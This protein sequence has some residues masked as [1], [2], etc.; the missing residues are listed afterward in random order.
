[1]A[2]FL[3]G[4]LGSF[5]GLVGTV[6]GG[7]WRGIDYIRSRPTVSKSGSSV[8][9]DVHRARFSLAIRFASTMNNLFQMTFKG[10]TKMTGSNIAFSNMMQSSV[11]GVY[12]DLKIDYPTVLIGRGSLQNASAPTVLQGIPGALKFQWTDNT[13][14]GTAQATDKTIMVAYCEELNS[15]VY[16][17]GD[18]ERKDES[19]VLKVPSFIGKQVQTW[20]MF[21]TNDSKSNSSSI[22]TGSL[23]VS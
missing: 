11:V 2:K 12:P 8:A 9:Q 3:K 23:V 6:V 4:I 18:A 10:T 21:I 19:G 16:T 14:T 17:I 1:M 5:S 7:R 15:T 20:L 22:F 13:G